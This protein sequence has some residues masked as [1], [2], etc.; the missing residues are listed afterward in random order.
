MYIIHSKVDTGIE[1]SFLDACSKL[2][3]T[4]EG[5]RVTNSICEA[6]LYQVLFII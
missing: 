6:K 2:R 4:S 1:I 3:K 5:N